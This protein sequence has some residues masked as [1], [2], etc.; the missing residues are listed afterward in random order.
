MRNARW[1]VSVFFVLAT[2]A[3]AT[4]QVDFKELARIE[5][6]YILSCQYV[7][8][9]DPAS[10]AINNVYG[11]P[12]WVVPRENALAILALVQAA[13]ILDDEQYIQRARLAADYLVRIQDTD[14]AWY[15]QY[16]Y[17]TA[18]DPDNPDS[19]ETLAKSPT[20]AAEV[21]I[22]LYRLGY[23]SGYY[24][25]MKKAAGYLIAC[26]NSGGNGFLLG[27]GKDAQGVFRS[28]RWASDNAFA[29]QALKAA[30]TWAV[31]HN[32]LRFALFCSRSARKIA[33]GINRNLYIADKKD[34][35][36]GVWRRVVDEMN[37]PVEPL[38]H[39]WINYAPQ[40]LD[41]P[42]K[43]VNNARV[44]HWIHR[45]L[46]NE[47]FACVWDDTQFPHRESPGYTFQ[48]VLC[49]RDLG[50][51]EY[52]FKALIWAL[53]SGLWKNTIDCNPAVGGW[54]DWQDTQT[55][56]QSPCWQ[57]FIDTSFYSIAAF[58]GGYAFRVI[59]SFLRIS[60]SNP[61][62]TSGAPCYLQ[63]S[64]PETESDTE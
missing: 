42:C 18:G 31:M 7:S 47:H 36:Y 58:N 60:Y 41:L 34:P 38:R 57:R 43:G 56:E 21:M 50:Q 37:I 52:F 40:M 44:G 59:P 9:T 62:T 13:E 51:E 63:L 24:P 35:D 17:T 28:W 48:A 30:E 45:T 15:N 6:D 2:A 64:F 32:D 29:F 12:T 10:G 54:V 26:Q 14:G 1:M 11:L 27:G 25:A 5:A 3:V 23:E 16:R 8:E 46:Q 22:A 33:V 61:K 20:Q 39:D 49:W 19:S 53:N 4:A 55:G